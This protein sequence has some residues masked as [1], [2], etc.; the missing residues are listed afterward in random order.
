MDSG[1]C[2]PQGLLP[3]DVGDTDEE[4]LMGEKPSVRFR[5]SEAARG[6]SSSKPVALVPSARRPAVMMSRLGVAEYVGED[7]D[8]EMSWCC[9]HSAALGSAWKSSLQT[10]WNVV[11]KL[12]WRLEETRGK[13]SGREIEEEASGSVSK[14]N[15]EGVGLDLMLEFIETHLGEKQGDLLM[16]T[17]LRH[18]LSFYSPNHPANSGGKATCSE[19]RTLA[20]GMDDV[21]RGISPCSLYMLM[22][23]FKAITVAFKKF[24][25]MSVRWGEMFAT[26]A[27]GRLL[28]SMRT[29]VS[30]MSRVAI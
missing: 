8:D 10:R 28:R 29:S 25:W 24:S 7:E 30:V 9:S 4:E 27:E 18:L 2:L 3:L 17:A 11:A 16:A 15:A 21:L 5:S 6:S 20:E 19:L 26:D 12:A 14:R 1:V 22:Q 23:R 13:A